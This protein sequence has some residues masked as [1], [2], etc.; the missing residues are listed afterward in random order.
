MR[1]AYSIFCPYA[2]KVRST[3]LIFLECITFHQASLLKLDDV[4]KVVAVFT[5][6]RLFWV[7]SLVYPTYTEIQQIWSYIA[8]EITCLKKLLVTKKIIRTHNVQDIVSK[9][10]VAVRKFGLVIDSRIKIWYC[11]L[12]YKNCHL[13]LLCLQHDFGT[14]LKIF[15]KFTYYFDFDKLA[16][17]LRLSRNEE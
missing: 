6:H 4:H 12:S 7:F 17:T 9:R 11:S 14:I 8:T 16:I 10:Y 13:T 5:G 2:F 1:G 15:E 3:T